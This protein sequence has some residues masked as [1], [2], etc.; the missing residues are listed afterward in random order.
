MTGSQIEKAIEI[1]LLFDHRNPVQTVRSVSRL[2]ATPLSSTYR[3]VNELIRV[4]L[5]ERI[6]NG[7][8][9]TTAKLWTL[10]VAGSEVLELRRVALPLMERLFAHVHEHIQLA[11]L[12]DTSVIYVESLEAVGGVRSLALVG[13]QM[14]ARLNSAGILLAAFSPK[15]V[16]DKVISARLEYHWMLT[17]PPDGLSIRESTPTELRSLMHEARLSNVCKLEGWLSPDSA[18]VSVPIRNGET[19]VAALSSIVRSDTDAYRRI[20]PHLIQ[21]AQEIGRQLG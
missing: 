6:E 2:S 14:P 7:S 19:V 20:I 3:L 8:L 4:G 18:G 10:G 17:Q 21:T 9:V 16:Q 15:E 11:I 1:L 5:L 13:E 12:R